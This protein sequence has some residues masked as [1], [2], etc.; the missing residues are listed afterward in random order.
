MAMGLAHR[1]IDQRPR[2]L[3]EAKNG[4]VTILLVGVGAALVVGIII[5]FFF[6]R[7]Q[8]RKPPQFEDFV[9]PYGQM[10]AI[11]RRPSVKSTAQVMIGG[12]QNSR[13]QHLTFENDQDNSVHPSSSASS[14]AIPRPTPST[15]EDNQRRYRQSSR[16]ALFEEQGA[17]ATTP[18]ITPVSTKSQSRFAISSATSPPRP[19]PPNSSVNRIELPVAEQRI[20]GFRPPKQ[21]KPST[22]APSS[23]ESSGSSSRSKPTSAEAR[24][25]R[26]AQLISQIGGSGMANNMKMIQSTWQAKDSTDDVKCTTKPDVIK[27]PT[28]PR[29]TASAARFH[30]QT[31]SLF[32]AHMHSQEDDQQYV[33]DANQ[34]DDT[35]PLGAEAGSYARNMHKKQ[36]IQL[37]PNPLSQ[38]Q[39]MGEDTRYL[40]VA[41]NPDDTLPLG[42]EAGTYRQKAAL[43]QTLQA[44]PSTISHHS[45]GSRSHCEHAS[46]DPRDEYRPFED[47]TAYETSHAYDSMPLGAEAG[48]YHQFLENQK[49]QHQH[50]A[51]QIQQLGR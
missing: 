20:E 34:P 39:G 48:Q 30:V 26:K 46:V 14:S 11:Q 8:R 38:T 43:L 40:T 3:E 13:F 44:P 25:A 42:A 1:M 47:Y 45:N 12:T 16:V 19:T 17:L 29:P 50:K 18:A 49:K 24:A 28:P 32:G 15:Y 9:D 27:F 10:D 6:K 4:W 51:Q 36:L 2:A 7:C 21:P 23:K 41:N 31:T 5:V 22:K 33:T 37:L 35:L